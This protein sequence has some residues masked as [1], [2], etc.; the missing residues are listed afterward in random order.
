M[1]PALITPERSGN[2]GEREAEC[3]R[4][5]NLRGNLKCQVSN[6]NFPSKRLKCMGT[7]GDKEAGDSAPY[8]AMSELTD[9]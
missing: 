2:A 4:K 9:E 6:R 8:E 3:N 1:S 5:I 7:L